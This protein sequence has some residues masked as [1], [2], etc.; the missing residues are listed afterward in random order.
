MLPIGPS[1][2]PPESTHNT[3]KGN[4]NVS[5][6]IINSQPEYFLVLFLLSPF[7]VVGRGSVL[8]V[9]VLIPE[10]NKHINM[11]PVS[12]SVGCARYLQRQPLKRAAGTSCFLRLMPP[13]TQR[14]LTHQPKAILYPTTENL[15]G[16][17]HE[18]F[19]YF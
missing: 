2:A 13:L 16:H 12:G 15:S 3:E 19:V 7:L 11:E 17:S 10:G 6:K 14:E 8:T 18:G 5:G 4:K 1:Q 9:L